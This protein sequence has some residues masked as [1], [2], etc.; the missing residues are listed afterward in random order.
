M[1]APATPSH[2]TPPARAPGAA[3]PAPRWT[4]AVRVLCDLAA[5]EGDLDHRFNPSPTAEQGQAGH[6][7]ATRRRPPGW[8]AEVALAAEVA[9][10]GGVLRVRGRADGVDDAG[11]CVEEVKTC[12]GDPARLPANQRTLHWAQAMVYGA[13][14][15]AA[16]TAPDWE[17]A[18]VYVDA[19]SH[20]AHPRVARRV[21]A[22][23]LQDFLHRLAGRYAAWAAREAVH[24]VE[25]DAALRGLAFPHGRFR[26]GQRELAEAVFRSARHGRVLLAQAPTGIGKTV[27]TLFPALRAVPEAGLD[28]VLFLTAKGSGRLAA[29]EALRQVLGGHDPA[30][31]APARVRV[32]ELTARDKACEHPGSACHGDSCPLARGFYDRLPA[33]REAAAAHPGALDRPALRT[34]A[35]AHQVCPYYL[36]QE[37]ARWADVVVGDSNHWL[38]VAAGLHTLT[39]EHGWRVA[40]LI[41]EA[42]HV[43][44]RARDNHSVTL[45]WPT[46]A[47]ARRAAP[48]LRRPLD[49]L[50]RAWRA[51]ADAHWPAGAAAYQVLPGLPERWLAALGDAIGAVGDLLAEAPPPWPQAVLDLHFAALHWR[52]LAELYD[53]AHS[54]V[55]GHAVDPA[56]SPHARGGTGGGRRPPP[57]A[58]TLRNVTPADHLRPRWA[59]AHHVTLFSATLA[60]R[61]FQ[62]DNLGLPDDCAWLDVPAPFSPDQLALHVVRNV[63]TRWAD[64]ARSAG[65]IA[66][67]VERQFQAQPGNYLAFFS[68]FD[69]LHQ[70][71]DALAARQPGWPLWRQTRGM[72]AAATEAFLAQFVEG[73]RGIGFAVLGG[74]F[75]EGVDL[76]GT[77]LIG[78]FVATLGLPPVSP[79]QD[80]LRERLQQRFGDGFAYACLYPGLR[81]VVQAAGRVV[82]TPQDQ[83]VVYLIDDRFGRADVQRLLPGWWP[84]PRLMRATARPGGD[85]PAQDAGPSQAGP[86]KVQDTTR[87]ASTMKCVVQVDAAPAPSGAL[88]PTPPPTAVRPPPPMP[89]PPM[90]MPTVAPEPSRGWVAT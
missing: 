77:R 48:A 31:T 49:R 20:E 78:A 75:A 37:M 29:L 84:A 83:G 82:R 22:A 2:D 57:P 1:S 39:L 53:P 63:S 17:V 38:D 61:R 89:N 32:L 14:C 9:V 12:R 16:A 18:V 86:S 66:G 5:R 90:L 55:D 70:V 41:D 69:Y 73:G 80:A 87:P 88:M 85:L 51:L 13:L 81:K 33:A 58:L 76:P 79:V 30:A 36:A 6:L 45:D 59:A 52:R 34:V 74:A 47:A 40:V 15:C 25:R 62:A 44:D 56:R 43:I 7:A 65:P 46:L 28:K 19:V 72:D 64:R 11:R 24:R 23:E 8:K 67:L 26:A 60:P 35:A 4:V 54:M 71:A 21:P 27:G 42:H 10:P 3:A 68:S 50:A